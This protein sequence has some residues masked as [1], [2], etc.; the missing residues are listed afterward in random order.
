MCFEKL[1]IEVY[2]FIWLGYVFKPGLNFN[3]EVQFLGYVNEHISTAINIS[4]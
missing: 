3:T 4:L 1:K 2:G